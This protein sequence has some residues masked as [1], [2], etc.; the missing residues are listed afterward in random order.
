MEYDDA[1]VGT[2]EDLRHRCRLSAIDSR[3]EV[4][5][6][7]GLLRRLLIDGSA[8]GPLVARQVG[9][10]PAFTW[11]S[12]HQGDGGPGLLLDPV[13]LAEVAG[14]K[15]LNALSGALHT[16]GLKEFLKQPVIS[17]PGHRV[18]IR[19]LI[20]HYANV[21]GGVH[22]AVERESPNAVLSAAL[23]SEHQEEVL[24]QTLVAVGRVTYRALEP[25][26]LKAAFPQVTFQ[27]SAEVEVADPPS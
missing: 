18:T 20:K 4:V 24:R 15:H 2:M 22:V 5:Q 17:V 9:I 8:L 26:M 1:L 23:E 25:V 7:S 10:V 6:A 21:E 27:L 14:E 16:E 12:V 19:E 11:Y 3:Y 13:I